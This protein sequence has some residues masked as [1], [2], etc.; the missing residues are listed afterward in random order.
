MYLL[1]IELFIID[2]NVELTALMF[3]FVL[4]FFL[5]FLFC[6]Y[7]FLTLSPSNMEFSV[8]YETTLSRQTRNFLGFHVFTVICY[9]L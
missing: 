6:A 8:I 7:L 9:T 2:T 3:L 5:Y 4:S 1:F